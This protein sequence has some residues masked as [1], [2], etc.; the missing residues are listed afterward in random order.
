[1]VERASSEAMALGELCQRYA[2][3]IYRYIHD[4]LPDRAIAEDLT[5]NVFHRALRAMDRYRPPTPFGSLLYGALADVMS[6]EPTPADAPDS[7]ARLGEAEIDPRF[8]RRLVASLVAERERLV[9]ARRKRWWRPAMN[10]LVARRRLALGVTAAAAALLVLLLAVQGWM[11]FPM[12]MPMAVPVTARASVA[13]LP[14]VDPAST[15]SV[16]FSRPMD[17]AAVVQA[18]RLKPATAVRTAWRGDRLLVTPV[19]GF[20]PNSPYVL[21]IS[22]SGARTASGESL[23]ANLNVVFGTAPKAILR[24]PSGAPA[25]LPLT[26]IAPAEEGSRAVI[27]ADGSIVATAGTEQWGPQTFSGLISFHG[28]S[29]DRLAPAA[30][31]ICVSQTG[32]SLA[33]LLG[34]GAGAQIVVTAW[35]GAAG[36]TVAAP[37]DDG[38]PLGWIGDGEV[39]FV[40]GGHLEAVDRGGTL[41]RLSGETVDAAHD[42]VV[43]SPGGRYVFLRSAEEGRAGQ[44][45]VLDLLRHSAHQLAGIVGDPAFSE[46]GATVVWID[47][48]RSSL[49]L[50]SGSSGGG[51]VLSVALPVALG[52]RVSDLAVAPDG[53][54]L[55]Y[56]VTHADGSGGELRV[57][58]L[59]DGATL[60]A[61]AAG[62]GQS[63][64]WSPTGTELAVLGH[65]G[66]QPEIQVAAAGAPAPQAVRG[67]IA[68]LANAQIAQ[69]AG[70]IDALADPGVPVDELPRASRIDVVEVVPVGEDA[71]RAL[72]RLLVDPTSADPEARSADETLRL[73]RDASGRVFVA[74]AS[75]TA[76]WDVSAGPHVVRV[77]AGLRPGT[78][79][80]TF[81][82]DLEASSVPA[83]TLVRAGGRDLRANTNYDATT[84]TVTVT[85]PGAAGPVT[86]FETTSLRDISGDPLSEPYETMLGS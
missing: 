56:S 63:P 11:A 85:V 49:R 22:R 15:V 65:P 1:V 41:H 78:V 84:R 18:L 46:D 60:A 7:A 32:R 30:A 57:A 52:D 37:V 76:L 71:W 27:T 5:S 26:S 38:S 39:A 14:S 12:P 16:S 80:V 23:A 31:A 47:S 79:A 45:R 77:E 73:R 68:S 81:D 24:A 72:L 59:S 28:Q 3:P 2:P 61:S 86:L 6:A 35:D 20:T 58:D 48:G 44:G 55:A 8:L 66:G 64:S 13:G 74:N 51:P 42:T 25:P 19:H 67:V 43:M 17:R 40:S 62:T 69:D 10:R 36:Q 4:R 82:A 29:F 33:Y 70:A 53:G 54:R 75:A 83:A 50:D 21:T 9:A 34:S